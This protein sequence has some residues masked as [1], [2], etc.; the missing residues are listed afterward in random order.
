VDRLLLRVMEE[1]VVGDA[2]D[3][4]AGIAE[5][6]VAD[7]VVRSIR[8][9]RVESLRIDFDD[10]SA[11][12]VEKVDTSNPPV[13][14]A[15]VDLPLERTDSSAH[16][17]LVESR[18]EIRLRWSMTHW[19]LKQER[20]HE[21]RA[22]TP[23]PAYFGKHS[24]DRGMTGQPPRPRIVD[25]LGHPPRTYIRQR[26]EIEECPSRC[27]HAHAI[28]FCDVVSEHSPG[29]MER[30]GQCRGRAAGRTYPAHDRRHQTKA[31]ELPAGGGRFMGDTAKRIDIEQR[32][33]QHR[34]RRLRCANDT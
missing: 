3:L 9:R 33:H 18:L 13:L 11:R 16:R 19:P 32:R 2:Y 4:H 8:Q 5:R 6:T 24:C 26:R 12:S 27:R 28:V 29:P 7:L 31:C 34:R 22:G 15:Y 14:P 17:Q 30:S 10:D 25:Q 20:S 21:G 23:A 1:V